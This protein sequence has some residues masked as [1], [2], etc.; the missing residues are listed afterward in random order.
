[1]PDKTDLVAVSAL[2][3]VWADIQEPEVTTVRAV[4]SV[5]DTEDTEE[6]VVTTVARADTRVTMV[7]ALGRASDLESV[8][9]LVR[10]TAMV[11]TDWAA[12]EHPVMDMEV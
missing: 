8:S 7:V 2:V 1:L 5:E 11:D 9:E 10:A 12:T 4:F 3:S 6:P